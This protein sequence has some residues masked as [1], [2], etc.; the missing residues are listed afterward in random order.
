ML[1]FTVVLLL[2]AGGHSA[3]DAL[4]AHTA[5]IGQQSSALLNLA[6]VAAKIKSTQLLQCMHKICCS[7]RCVL[8]SIWEPR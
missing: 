6:Q 8:P 1:G 3:M 5:L 2:Y 4:A 7:V